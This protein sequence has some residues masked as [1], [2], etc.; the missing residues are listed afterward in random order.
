[1]ATLVVVGLLIGLL[2]WRYW[3]YSDP[4]RGLAPARARIPV[5]RPPTLLA[6]VDTGV[7]ATT[8]QGIYGEPTELVTSATMAPTSAWSAG[9]HDDV[10]LRPPPGPY[11]HDQTAVFTEDPTDPGGWPVPDRQPV[12]SRVTAT[13]IA[14]WLASTSTRC[15]SASGTGP[16]P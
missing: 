3:R 9:G 1:M 12:G 2:T 8:A 15:C 5:S 14:P 10:S 6:G 4:K 16:T 7:D 11:D 13:T